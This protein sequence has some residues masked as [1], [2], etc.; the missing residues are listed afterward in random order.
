MLDPQEAYKNSNLLLLHSR[1]NINTGLGGGGA[2]KENIS[3]MF[4]L[5]CKP[6]ERVR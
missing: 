3:L 4:C 5:P 1:I 2:G 6:Q